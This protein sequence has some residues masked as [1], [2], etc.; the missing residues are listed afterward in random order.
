MRQHLCEGLDGGQAH[1]RAARQRTI[2]LAYVLQALQRGRGL[3][4]TQIC[5]GQQAQH[6]HMIIHIS[7]T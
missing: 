5:L 6:L 3:A 1:G 4:L 7:S 2:Q